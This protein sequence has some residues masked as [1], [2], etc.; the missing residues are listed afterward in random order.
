M[1]VRGRFL[2]AGQWTDSGKVESGNDLSAGSGK[3]ED[4]KFSVEKTVEIVN[5]SSIFFSFQ[6]LYGL[7]MGKQEETPQIRALFST[8]NLTYVEKSSGCIFYCG[9]YSSGLFRWVESA[10]HASGMSCPVRVRTG[11]GQ[12]DEHG[13]NPSEDF[14]VLD[15]KV[16][17]SRMIHNGAL[18]QTLPKGRGPFGIP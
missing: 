15:N 6:H 1:S 12:Y 2:N 5:T 7:S 3:V 11:F 16:S 18:H 4:A 14:C 9:M 17:A 8:L 13:E 10:G